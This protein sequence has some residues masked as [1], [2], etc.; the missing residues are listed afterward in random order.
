M[1]NPLQEGSS[2]RLSIS[3]VATLAFVGLMVPAAI[4]ATRVAY[5][6]FEAPGWEGE[7]TGQSRWGNHV[8]RVSNAPR[9]G[10]Y[11]LRGNQNNN[12]VDPITGLQGITNAL[13]DWRGAGHDID[14]QTPNEMYFSYWF[15][16]DDYTW[17]GDGAGGKLFYFI[18]VNYN[19]RAMYVGQQLAINGLTV[20]YSNGDYDDSWARDEANWG[21]AALWLN[22]PNVSPSTTGTWRH[23]EYYINYN[24]HYF[25]IWVDGNLLT[26]SN[27]KYPDGK[28][29]YDPN[30][31]IHWKGI[32]F[33]YTGQAQVDQSSDGTGYYNGWQLD[34]LEVWDGMPPAGASYTLTVNSGTGDG[35]YTAGTV[36]SIAAD[37]APSGHIFDVWTGDT[38]GIADANAAS[39]TITMPAADV[40]VTA[41]YVASALETVHFREG[42]GSGYTDVTFDDTWINYNPADDTTHGNDGYNGIQCSSSQVTLIAVKDMFA[43]LPKTTGGNDIVIQ[44]AT[45]HLFRY[46]AGTNSNTLSIYPVTSD[47]LPDVAGANENDVSGQHSE[48]SSG[49]TWADGNFSSSDYDNSIVA[50]GLWVNNYDAECLL[51]VTNVIASIYADEI[52]YGMAVFADGLIIGRASENGGNR[53]SLEI[54]Y[55]YGSSEPTYQLTVSSGTGDGSY[56]VG[57]VVNISADAA[58]S[59]QGF[60]Q[61]TGDVADVA[62]TLAAATTVTMPPAAVEVTATYKPI[63]IP[64]DLNG[65]GFVGQDDLDIVLDQWGCG[66]P[67]A[68]PITDGRADASGDGFVGQ[69]DLDIVLDH[70]GDGLPQQ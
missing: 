33:F 14:T 63:A 37:A 70:W 8:K 60:D 54:T 67:P 4:G 42:G 20:T 28:I 43:E 26:P 47:W 45:L 13:L 64:G 18:D 46:N 40:T 7:F 29:A 66:D 41:T 19:T 34:D 52:N 59:G 15:R 12:R 6:G 1:T 27:G 58:P 39:T 44:S 57:T 30:L 21:Y 65:D 56:T 10:S 51:D 68:D 23:F 50:T 62:D 53:P 5:Q 25:M 32:Q 31:N 11:C 38:S 9:S 61:W 55:Q 48:V 24:D 3:M 17:A 35:S 36:V 22:H 49:T 2:S 16:H 69:D